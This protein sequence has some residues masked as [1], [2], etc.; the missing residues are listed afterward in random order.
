MVFITGDCH[1]E[2]TRFSTRNFPI[3]KELTHDDYVIICGDFGIWHDSSEER[4]WLRWLSEKPFTTLFV[5]GNHE[6]FD[7][8]DSEF[9]EI[10]FCGGRAHT[11]RDNVYHLMRGQVFEID[12]K[13][14]FTF[15]GARSHDI[16][17]GILDKNDF[18]THDEFTQTMRKM[19][20]EGKFFRVN[21]Y[22]WWEREMP[23]D[24][25][26]RLALKNLEKNNFKVDYIITHCCPQ[27]VASYFGYTDPDNLTKFFNTLDEVVEY[28]CWFFGHYHGD[29]KYDRYTMLYHNIELIF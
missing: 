27:T 15:G 21:H 14:F 4:Y 17:D 18:E 2:F 25:E 1:G 11:I 3:Q 12:G 19:T 16:Q 8:L 24:D 22:S 28:K 23:S 7:R 26:K 29:R 6:N 20:R 5:D 13:K 9:N 10:D